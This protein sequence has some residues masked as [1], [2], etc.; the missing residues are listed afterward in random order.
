MVLGLYVPVFI[1]VMAH[2]GPAAIPPVTLT[3]LLVCELRDRSASDEGCALLLLKQPVTPELAVQL[4]E[5]NRE[6]LRKKINEVWRGRK[7]LKSR[8]SIKKLELFLAKEFLPPTTPTERR[9]KNSPQVQQLLS[10]QNSLIK[11]VICTKRKLEYADAARNDLFQET[12]VLAEKLATSEQVLAGHVQELAGLRGEMLELSDEMRALE[13]KQNVSQKELGKA[14]TKLSTLS[15]RNIHKRFKARDNRISVLQCELTS[16]KSRIQEQEVLDGKVSLYKELVANLQHQKCNLQVKVSRLKKV[17]NSFADKSEHQDDNMVE[18]ECEIK[19]LTEK[20]DELTQLNNLVESNHIRTFEDGKYINDMREC[21]ML[22]MTEC[23]VSTA[24]LPSVIDTVLKKL[25]GKDTFR[26]PSQPFL[27][28]LYT[29]ARIVASQQIVGTMLTNYDATDMTGNVLHQDATTK[30]HQHWEGIQVTNKDGTSLSI[31]LKQV[32]G[33]DANTYV[34]AFKD[35]IKDLTLAVTS[36]SSDADKKRS[37][38]ITS[39]KSLMSD[40]CSTNGLFNKAIHDIREGLLPAVIK[41]FDQLPQTEK[42]E[43]AEMGTFACRMHLLANLAPAADKALAAYELSV[44]EDPQNPESYQSYG[45]GT[46]RL[47]RSAAKA[48]TQRGCDKAGV[49]SYFE[50]FL[51]SRGQENHLVTFHGHRFNIA[52]YDAAAVYYHRKDITEFLDAWPNPNGL[53]KAVTFDVTQHVFLA[54]VRALGM[55]HKLV[56]EPLQSLIKCSGS[57]LDLNK[58]LFALQSTLSEWMGDGA[59]PFSGATVFNEERVHLV[60]D[61][62]F[63][64]LFASTQDAY[65]DSLTQ[66]ALKLI[67]TEM[68]ILLERQA[69]S[70]LPEGELW[71]PSSKMLAMAKNVPK[72]NII[73]ERDMAI[74]DNLLRSKPAASATLIETTVLWVNNKPSI[75]LDNLTLD[76]RDKALNEAREKAPAYRKLV[77]ERQQL[78]KEQLQK[79]LKCKQQEK[80]EREGKAAGYKLQLSRE[81]MDICGGVWKKEEIHSHLERIAR[82]VNI[83][84]TLTEREEK[85]L[86]ESRSRE[87]LLKQLKFNKVVIRAKGARSLFQASCK[88]KKFSSLQLLENL[89]NVLDLNEHEPEENHEKVVAYKE[90]DEREMAVHE[91]KG[92]MLAQLFEARKKRKRKQQQCYLPKLIA[93]PQLLVGKTVQHKC[94]EEGESDWFDGNVLSIEKTTKDPAKTVYNIRYNE[95]PTHIMA[96][97]LIAEL[98]KGN[99]IIKD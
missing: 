35:T 87:V 11:E 73:S 28:R 82:E 75:W 33:G 46:H 48:F 21:C 24:K 55:V 10:A 65:M 52:F 15:T 41:N 16:L 22:L 94:V 98:R 91:K 80:A 92:R 47:V 26:T 8:K 40:Q 59:K 49:H 32:A 88:G 20:V 61:K 70:Q 12:E 58:D 3:N 97:S 63:D 71:D 86:I 1:A 34:M 19:M 43:I 38:L 30:F 67:S 79:R 77:K 36:S 44:C 85:A 54:G 69:A 83:G 66:V 37:Q 72:H 9:S 99:L 18:Y 39:L 23:N 57:I 90:Q 5:C 76:E 60:K 68:L 6:T 62:L 4:T 56:T 64:A 53:L 95:S 89:R 25:T 42:S 29:E 17:A 27:S 93:D 96:F 14:K 31:G 45:S 78:L 2:N 50:T 7:N 74:L 51:R 84:K 81:I 13:L